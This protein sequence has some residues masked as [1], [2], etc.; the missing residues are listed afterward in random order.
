[1]K[2]HFD[3]DSVKRILSNEK[4]I[5]ILNALMIGVLIAGFMFLYHG[6]VFQERARQ[7]NR[8]NRHIYQD[9]AEGIRDRSA[10]ADTVAHPTQ[11]TLR[12]T[13]QYR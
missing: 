12:A 4:G 13:D 11:T 9:M 3:G 10:M 6:E 7:Q 5:T 8:L 2:A 1:M